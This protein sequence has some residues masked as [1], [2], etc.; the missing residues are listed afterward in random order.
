MDDLFS[1]GSQ[2]C[3]GVTKTLAHSCYRIRGDFAHAAAFE[4]LKD[5]DH[6]SS[7]EK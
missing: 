5:F 6:G 2:L 1:N 4:K 3:F 7:T